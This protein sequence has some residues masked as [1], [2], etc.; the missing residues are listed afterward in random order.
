MKTIQNHSKMLEIL[1]KNRNKNYGAYSI[2]IAYDKTLAKSILMIC[3][4]LTALFGSYFFL[5]EPVKEIVETGQIEH[6]D[7]L[8]HIEFKLKE[9]DQPLANNNPNQN[10]NQKPQFDNN[11]G[12]ATKISDN[13]NDSL[14]TNTQ[15]DPIAK[16]IDSTST[17]NNNNLSGVGTNTATGGSGNTFVNQ[18]PLDLYALDENPEFEGG[19]DALNKFISKHIQYPSSAAEIG[20]QGT[21]YVQFIVD[22]NGR[23]TGAKL[24]NNIGF[25]LDKEALRVVNLIPDFR[26]PGKV[27]GKAVKTNFLLPIKFKIG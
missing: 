25:G 23:V 12:L 18:P 4:I 22:E 20:K 14:K 6:L 26:S 13:L 8:I 15:D 10:K 16:G 24:K 27:K 19:L 9:P 17:T 3:L 11:T 21:L 5:K 2:R 1:F 7:S